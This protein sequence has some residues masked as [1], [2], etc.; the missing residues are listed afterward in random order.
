MIGIALAVPLAVIAAVWI[1]EYGKPAPLARVVES[2]I[3]VVAGTP[4]I[5]HRDLR[6]GDLPARPLRPAVV[7]RLGRR[8]LRPLVPR[9]GRDDVADR[10]AA[11]LRRH[12]RRACRR[13]PRHM[14][15]AALALGKTR[16]ATIR[17]VLL[18]S[19]RSNIATGATL[20]IS[21]IIGDTA[22]VVLLLGA[23]LR[24]EPQGYVPG[25][26]RAARHRLDADQL[27]LRQLARG[28]R[29]RAAEGLR[30]GLRAAVVRPV[31]STSRS[32][33]IGRRKETRA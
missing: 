8:R 21:R 1:A 2:S 15:E 7:H 4:D 9:G 10:A 12:A 17:R 29:Q 31:R 13:C 16:I 33:C 5:V 23:T 22:I 14:R 6:P 3:E 20:G 27:R 32:T 25:P 26:R 24:I 19:V 28:R 18:P 30:R 11:G